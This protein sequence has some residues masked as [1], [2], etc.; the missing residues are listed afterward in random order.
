MSTQ[1]PYL[2]SFNQVRT[3]IRDTP[4]E[5]RF[6]HFSVESLRDFLIPVLLDLRGGLRL[7]LGQFLLLTFRHTFLLET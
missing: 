4:S 2:A 7:L 3:W 1:T 5:T 6:R